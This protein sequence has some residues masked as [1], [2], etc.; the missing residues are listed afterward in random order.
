[1]KTL[2]TDLLPFMAGRG[3][4]I[5]RNTL[6]A[7]DH[8]GQPRPLAEVN[9]ALDAMLGSY[10]IVSGDPTETSLVEALEDY[11]ATPAKE[12]TGFTRRFG[13]VAELWL[14][15]NWPDGRLRCFTLSYLVADD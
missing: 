12:P 4:Q 6:G 3:V 7:I 8:R 14:P 11:L 13:D 10:D 5:Q 15:T 2:D 1:M 9:L